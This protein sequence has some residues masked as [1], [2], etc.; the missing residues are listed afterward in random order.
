MKRKNLRS[1]WNKPGMKKN[2]ILQDL[3]PKSYIFIVMYP[4]V[5]KRISNLKRQCKEKTRTYWNHLWT[6]KPT[7]SLKYTWHGENRDSLGFW[8]Q[9]LYYLITFSLFKAKYS[10]NNESKRSSAFMSEWSIRR[11]WPQADIHIIRLQLYYRPV[12][13]LSLT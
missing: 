13:S 2:V 7:Q 3:E 12:K 9:N 11:R 10:V 1:I 6:T 4:S 8:T 5:D